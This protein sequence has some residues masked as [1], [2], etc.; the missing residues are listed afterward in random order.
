MK[1]QYIIKATTEKQKN[2]RHATARALHYAPVETAIRQNMRFA[3]LSGYCHSSASA[4]CTNIALYTRRHWTEACLV[5][6]PMKYLS[7]K[8]LI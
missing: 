8:Q 6:K 5:Q 4:T 1:N 7:L 3:L 2:L